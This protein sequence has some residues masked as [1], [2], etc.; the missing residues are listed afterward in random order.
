MSGEEMTAINVTRVWLAPTASRRRGCQG[1][2]VL[3]GHRRRGHAISAL[4]IPG[5]I[6]MSRPI[7]EPWP[8]LIRQTLS[9]AKGGPAARRAARTLTEALYPVVQARVARTLWRTRRSADRNVQQEVADMTQ[10]VFR[11]LFDG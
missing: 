10:D 3:V 4:R 6:A 11:A 7:S 2:G 9:G 1:A 8:E 5:G